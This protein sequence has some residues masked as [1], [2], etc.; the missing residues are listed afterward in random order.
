MVEPNPT[1][2]GVDRNGRY[3]SIAETV[4]NVFCARH[5]G[6]VCRSTKMNKLC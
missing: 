1:R 4:L 5:R 6:P 2:I 3:E